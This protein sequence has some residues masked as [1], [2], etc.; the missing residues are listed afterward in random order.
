[1][2]EP[3]LW[4]PAVFC[5]NL[6]FPAIICGFLRFPAASQ[7]W[8]F[9][10]KGR[11]CENLRFSAKIRV[12]G[13]L[14]HLSSVPLSAPRFLLIFDR[15]RPNLVKNAP[16]HRLEIGSSK[17]G[18]ARCGRRSLAGSRRRTKLTHLHGQDVRD[19][20]LHNTACLNIRESQLMSVTFFAR[21]SRAG[22]GCANFMG[23]WNF[24]FFLQGNFDAR[25]NPHFGP[26]VLD[27][28]TVLQNWGRKPK[29]T[30]PS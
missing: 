26:G 9:Q 7:C 6:L 23:A 13:S 18:P 28:V 12:L 24:G 8:N 15:F 30:L 19:A 14:C 17:G 22:N 27:F 25:R 29:G 4:F 20:S 2:T 16:Q 21:N 1:M 3:N 5:E 11:C 10:E